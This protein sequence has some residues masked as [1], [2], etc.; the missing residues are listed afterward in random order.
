M[1]YLGQH[2][3]VVN[4]LGVVTKDFE[5]SGIM[6]I[7]EYCEGGSIEDFL[8]KNRIWFHDENNHE[9]VSIRST[10]QT[11]NEQYSEDN[12]SDDEPESELEGDEQLSNDFSSTGSQ[13]DDPSYE[14]RGVSFTRTDLLCWAFQVA[15]AMHFLTSRNVLHRDLAARNI[16][17]CTNN[18]VKICDFGLARSLRDR[19][20]KKYYKKGQESV[21]FGYLA[22]ESLSSKQKY[23]AYTDVWSFGI[24]LWEFFSLGVV[25]YFQENIGFTEIENYLQNGNRLKKP[26]HAP[27]FIYDIMTSCWNAVPESR[28]LFDSLEQQISKLLEP[29]LLQRFFDLNKVYMDSNSKNCE[30]AKNR[31]LA[32]LKSCPIALFF[33]QKTNHNND[34]TGGIPLQQL[35]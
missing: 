8:E 33:S 1:M 4:L 15:R 27:Q 21:P 28:P 16:L 22:P 14:K 6:I 23:S 20:T 24:V 5:N 3:N 18:V 34:F 13:F 12:Q 26:H 17:L 30:S 32:T 11:E 9:T 35:A 7:V 10:T 2:L 29:E 25:P 19:N 31:F